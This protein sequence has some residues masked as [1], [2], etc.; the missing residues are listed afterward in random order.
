MADEIE[1]KVI[2][3]KGSNIIESDPIAAALQELADLAIC[4][5][6]RCRCI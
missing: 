5:I 1:A 2:E 3:I 6:Y 4:R